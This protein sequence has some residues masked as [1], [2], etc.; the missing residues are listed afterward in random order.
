MPC[1]AAALGCGPALTDPS[2]T[3]VTGTW[4]AA[5]P[6]A[7]LTNVTVILTQQPDGSIS[8][9]YTATGTRN[10]QFCNATGPCSISGTVSGTNTVF[11]VFFELKDAGKFTGQVIAPAELKGAMTRINSNQ[12]VS[13]VKA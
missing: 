5:G 9:T 10:L 12:P 8:G 4:F 13:F 11:Q 1:V 3:D 2:G 7:G 6:A